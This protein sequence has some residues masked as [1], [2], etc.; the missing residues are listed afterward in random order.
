[1]SNAQE[2][3][4]PKYIA[5]QSN[6]YAVAFCDQG[7]DDSTEV[8]IAAS[9]ASNKE[10]VM[11]AEVKA[12]AEGMG[13][14]VDSAT[15]EQVAVIEANYAGQNGKKPK[16]TA[17]ANPFEEHK[18]EAKR[19]KEV[20]EVA[21]L[22]A[23]KREG[24]YEYVIG[25]EKMRDH[26]I[27]AKMS[28]Q[29]FKNELYE[30][31]VP[32]AHTVPSPRR[33]DR[34]LTARVLEAAICETGRLATLEKSFSDQELQAAHDR[35]PQGIGLN[36]LFILAAEHNGYKGHSTGGQVTLDIQRAA[37]GMGNGRQIQATGFSMIDV[38]TIVSNTANKFLREG[39]NTVE[40]RD[41]ILDQ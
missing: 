7:A 28:V 39:W 33:Q 32:M 15:D 38:A 18:L 31:M 2:V 23:S 40:T 27:E 35:F 11:K 30:S 1:M 22:W 29:E 5:R 6:I 9:A 16:S 34:G 26:A 25:I 41:A 20:N 17:A 36:Q 37:F 14:D 3:T 21:E 10:K 8:T 12:W 13:I 4:A 19:Q 24:D